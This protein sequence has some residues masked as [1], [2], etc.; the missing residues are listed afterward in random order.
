MSLDAENLKQLVEVQKQTLELIKKELD[1]LTTV[2][3]ELYDSIADL[4][5]ELL[6]KIHAVDSFCHNV[7]EP[8]QKT[9]WNKLIEVAGQEIE[10][11]ET[12]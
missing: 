12:L 10:S 9:I 8:N 6:Q 4:K 2:K 11:A 1:A 3:E 5:K 7:L